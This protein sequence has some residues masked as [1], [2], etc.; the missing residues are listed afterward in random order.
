MSEKDG[1]FS[2]VVRKSI[3]KEFFKEKKKGKLTND[4]LEK[5]YSDKVNKSPK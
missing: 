4:L 3:R 1:R 5:H 2:T